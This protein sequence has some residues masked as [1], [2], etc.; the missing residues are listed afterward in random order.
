MHH[1]LQVFYIL[2]A[3]HVSDITHTLLIPSEE[4]K[5]KLGLIHIS[6]L[7]LCGK[8]EQRLFLSSNDPP[9]SWTIPSRC[10]ADAPPF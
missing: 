8:R 3:S 10:D 2:S 7:K 9:K 6:R 4:T 1:I 5:Q